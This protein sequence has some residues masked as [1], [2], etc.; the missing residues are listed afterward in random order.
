MK[1]LVWVQDYL[2][3][4]PPN[5]GEG[6]ESEFRMFLE[7]VNT[8]PSPLASSSGSLLKNGEGGG[9]GRGEERAWRRGY[10]HHL[11]P[12]P[13]HY[14][15]FGTQCGDLVLISLRALT[16]SL[17]ILRAAGRRSPSALFTTIMSAS[18]TIPFFI[19]WGGMEKEKEEE[20][21]VEERQER[22]EV[23]EDRKRSGMK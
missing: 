5:S 11:T 16:Y 13:L 3:L 7:T 17:L 8:H 9:R 12:S 14:L 15:T 2:C 4:R 6:T 20:E 18:S 19:P 23:E 21:E 1:Y 10:P 22:G